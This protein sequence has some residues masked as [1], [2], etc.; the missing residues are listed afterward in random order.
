MNSLQELFAKDNSF[1]KNTLA[2]NKDGN[3]TSPHNLNATSWCIIGAIEKIYGSYQ[4]LLKYGKIIHN[5][6]NPDELNSD[7]WSSIIDWNN[8]PERTI[9]DIRKLVKE[10]NI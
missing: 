6:L 1:C 10:L 9:E 5:K 3:P 7:D 4:Q 2:T 8:A